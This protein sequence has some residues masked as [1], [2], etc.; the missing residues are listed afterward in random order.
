LRLRNYR[1]HQKDCRK[2]SSAEREKT[3]KQLTRAMRQ[4]RG[5]IIGGKKDDE[6]R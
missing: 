5:K 2:L 4:V 3:S 6:S 1:T